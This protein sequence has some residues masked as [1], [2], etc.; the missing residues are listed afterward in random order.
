M[1]MCDTCTKRFECRGIHGPYS[2]GKNICNE[3]RKTKKLADVR[4]IEDS[5][6]RPLTSTEL[7]DLRKKGYLPQ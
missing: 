3:Y 1:M 2:T 6:D 5:L 4:A 7:Y